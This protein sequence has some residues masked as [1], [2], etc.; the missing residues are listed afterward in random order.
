MEIVSANL[1]Y[2]SLGQ[3]RIFGIDRFLEKDGSLRSYPIRSYPQLLHAVIREVLIPLRLFY[4]AD[5]IGLS[6]D[7][8]GTQENPIEITLHE[9]TI[10]YS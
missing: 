9:D 2:V 6:Q 7:R 10:E 1:I 4:R 3:F 8:D 5:K